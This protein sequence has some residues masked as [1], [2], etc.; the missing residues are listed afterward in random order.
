MEFVDGETLAN[1]L[2]SEQD[3][4]WQIRLTLAE[5]IV[6]GIKCLHE[7]KPLV[8]AGSCFLAIMH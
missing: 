4:P 6:E 2:Y 7:N 8:G 1:L 5:E 3:I